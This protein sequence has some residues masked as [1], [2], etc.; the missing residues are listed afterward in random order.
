MR[1]AQVSFLFFLFT[2]CAAVAPDVSEVPVAPQPEVMVSRPTSAAQPADRASAPAASQPVMTA[3]PAPAA[4]T[5][6][7]SEPKSASRGT[8]SPAVAAPPPAASAS[9]ATAVKPATQSRV[10]TPSA[11]R[12]AL[13]LNGLKEQLKE[14]KAIGV[15]TKLTL[16]NQVDDLLQQFRDFYQGKAKVTMAQ[17]RRSYDLLLMKVLSLLQDAD[18]KLASAIVAS[19]EAI[20][21][22]LADPKK[23]ATLEG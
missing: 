15:F 6:P 20:W 11:E 7:V 16:K 5:A 12:P 22:L 17:L 18:Q 9:S 19:R 8:E 21:G 23:F 13:D 1:L 10:A 14:T 2:G 3:T 4:A